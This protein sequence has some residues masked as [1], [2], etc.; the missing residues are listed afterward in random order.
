VDLSDFGRPPWLDEME[1]FVARL[2]ESVRPYHDAVTKAVPPLAWLQE[3]ERSTTAYIKR[4]QPPK[5]MLDRLGQTKGLARYDEIEKQANLLPGRG[6]DDLKRITSSVTAGYESLSQA[7]TSVQAAY[8]SLARVTSTTRFFAD[9]MKAA[10]SLEPYLEAL[11]QAAARPFFHPLFESAT[12]AAVLR[13]V[14]PGLPATEAGE[15]AQAIAEDAT[16]LETTLAAD[17]HATALT[18]VLVLWDRL[19]QR[20]PKLGDRLFAV[21]LSLFFFLL[22]RTDDTKTEQRLNAKIDNLVITQTRDTAAL[23]RLLRKK[24]PTPR[25]KPESRAGVVQHA[26]ALRANRADNS[27]ILARLAPGQD[28]TILGSGRHWAHVEMPSGSKK[29]NG[30]VRKK[31]LRARDSF[32]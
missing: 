11:N 6:L 8:E 17:E 30:W 7:S 32:R 27:Q 16:D 15:V 9:L 23:T 12:L 19:H 21:L 4:F 31:Y 3:L 29:L 25:P 14:Q 22:G 5:E 1:R 28:V 10:P 13:Q 20:F 26:V 18:A 2:N 24:R